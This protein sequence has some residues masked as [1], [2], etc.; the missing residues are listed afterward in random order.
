MKFLI[1]IEQSGE[2]IRFSEYV[3]LHIAFDPTTMLV[4]VH[5]VLFAGSGVGARLGDGV[6]E[7]ESAGGSIFETWVGRNITRRVFL[8]AE[9]S[10]EIARIDFQGALGPASITSP[11]VILR[12]DVHEYELE[13]RTVEQR[14]LSS[15]PPGTSAGGN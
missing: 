4:D 15:A 10:A 1:V 3:D 12:N 6:H 2:Q 7:F 9:S 13:I 14:L 8:D 5:R 11:T